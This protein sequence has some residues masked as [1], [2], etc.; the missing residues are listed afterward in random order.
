MKKKK[1]TPGTIINRRARYDYELGDNLVVGIELTGQ[2]TK[3]LRQ[4]HAQLQ[5]SY[6]TVKDNELWLINA[7]ISSG[8]TFVIPEAEQTRS[9]KLLAN[10]KEI[11]KLIVAKQQGSTIV[12]VQFLTSGRYV[13]LKISIAKGKKKYDK[14]E[15]IKKREQSRTLQNF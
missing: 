6:V 5:G 9:R 15:V 2:E 12:P 7:L 11:D 14:R 10:R 8:K 13:K 1:T 4:G 3:S